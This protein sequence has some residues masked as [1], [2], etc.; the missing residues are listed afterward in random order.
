MKPTLA[1]RAGLPAASRL[2][3]GQR[4]AMVPAEAL[5]AALTEL[6][7]YRRQAAQLADRAHR[8]DRLE[9]VTLR[10]VDRRDEWAERA[11]LRSAEKRRRHILWLPVEKD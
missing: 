6:A 9:T 8:L 7:E 3:T 11:G 1:Q 4:L 5:A 2:L 10:V